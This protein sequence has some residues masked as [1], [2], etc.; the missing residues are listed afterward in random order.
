M[1]FLTAEWRKL[2]MANYEVP[3]VL[4]KPYLPAGTELDFW[5]GR[6]YVSLV[7]FMFLKTRV[8]GVPIPFHRNFEEVNL[9]FYVRRNEK[10]GVVFIRE[11]VPKPVIAW[12][13]NAVYQENYIACRMRHEWTAPEASKWSVA[14]EWKPFFGGNWLRFSA[15]ARS[16]SEPIKT[17][18]EEEFITEHYWGY[19]RASATKT[20]EYQVDHPRWEAYPVLS[21]D[22]RG[23]FARQYGGAFGEILSQKPESVLL[24]EGSPVSVLH[25]QVLR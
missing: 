1:P 15:I 20:H 7:G 22:I 17:D 3:P 4:L 8:M 10:R 25:K 16:G 24:A 14:Y 2:L 23:D 13:A 12:V 21:H 6:C 11:I 18:S 5:R 9:R 19:A